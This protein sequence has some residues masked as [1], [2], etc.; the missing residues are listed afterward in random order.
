MRMTSTTLPRLALRRRLVRVLVAGGLALALGACGDDDDSSGDATSGGD[1]GTGGAVPLEVTSA[2]D[3]DDVTAPAGGVIEIT[4]SSG[5]GHT[6]TTD[7]EAIDVSYGADETV[8]IDVPD[9][10]GEYPFHCE[11]HPSMTGTLT[12][13]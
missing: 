8:D 11:I 3:Y 7:D 10:P 9:E 4:N 13:T 1:G 12:A 6:F 5:V 2:S